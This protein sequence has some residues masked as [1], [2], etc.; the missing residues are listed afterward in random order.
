[1]KYQRPS[2]PQHCPSCIQQQ[3]H[4]RGVAVLARLRIRGALGYRVLR[5]LAGLHRA[6]HRGVAPSGHV[7]CQCG[8][9]CKNLT[10]SVQH[11][12]LTCWRHGSRSRHSRR[13]RS[14]TNKEAAK[15]NSR[16]T[17]VRVLAG[18][19]A[20][21]HF[22][23]HQRTAAAPA[24]RRSGRQPSSSPCPAHQQATVQCCAAELHEWLSA[25][26]SLA[27]QVWQQQRQHAC[28]NSTSSPHLGRGVLPG[29]LHAF[30]TCHQ[31]YI[32]LSGTSGVR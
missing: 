12:R 27:V 15:C 22:G 26:C 32:L 1:M 13:A 10:L 19:L 28:Y 2:W 16:R 5:G 31:G 4:S 18:Q 24:E 7:T 25:A 20:T 6:L 30:E 8:A 17:E 11:D 23:S 9:W 21:W 29:I 14:A 3:S